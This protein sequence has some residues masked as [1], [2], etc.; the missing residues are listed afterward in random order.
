[1]SVRVPVYL[2]KPARVLFFESD[3]VC[4]FVLFLCMGLTLGGWMHIATVAGPVAYYKIKQ[5]YPSGFLSHMIYFS[6]IRDFT[7]YPGFFHRHFYE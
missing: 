4:I 1:M 3:D 2:S 6:G 5:C 7:H